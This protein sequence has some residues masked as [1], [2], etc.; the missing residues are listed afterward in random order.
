MRILQSVAWIHSTAL[1]QLGSSV[2]GEIYVEL[3]EMKTMEWEKIKKSPKKKVRE[4]V[5]NI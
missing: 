1:Q 5:Y 3:Q 4:I 2:L